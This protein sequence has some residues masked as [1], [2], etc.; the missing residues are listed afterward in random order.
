M[1]PPPSLALLHYLDSFDLDM[2]YQLRERH[3]ATVAEMKRNVVSVE[4]NLL[5]KKSK[6]K[7]EKKVTIKEESSSSFDG[8]LNTLIKKMEIMIDIITIAERQAKPST[9]NPNYRGQ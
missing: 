4:A 2:A 5:I 1:K 3:L 9:R 6:L 8:K 7:P